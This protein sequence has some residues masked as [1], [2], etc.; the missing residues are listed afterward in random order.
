M[1]TH[2][3]DMLTKNLEEKLDAFIQKGFV[4]GRKLPIEERNDLIKKLIDEIV[5][6]VVIG[7]REAEDVDF[8]DEELIERERIVKQ[9]AEDYYAK[10]VKNEI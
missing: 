6:N 7:L 4:L 2:N 1:K 9:F 3:Q 10:K 8:T 5:D